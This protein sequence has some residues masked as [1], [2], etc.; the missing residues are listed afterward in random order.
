MKKYITILRKYQNSVRQNKFGVRSILAATI[1]KVYS[2]IYINIDLYKYFKGMTGQNKN[3]AIG[4][5]DNEGR[6]NQ[7][8]SE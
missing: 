7:I 2:Q 8:V 4:G 3:R 5:Y 1:L 6:S